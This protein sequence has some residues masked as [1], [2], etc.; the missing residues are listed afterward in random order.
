[1]SRSPAQRRTASLV[2]KQIIRIKT[3]TLC[4]INTENNSKKD[5]PA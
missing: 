3:T 4:T 1:M 2:A 5:K